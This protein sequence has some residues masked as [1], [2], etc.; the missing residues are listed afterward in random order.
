MLSTTSGSTG[1]AERS[2]AVALRSAMGALHPAPAARSTKNERLHHPRRPLFHMNGTVSRRRPSSLPTPRSWLLPAFETRSYIEAIAQIQSHAAADGRCR[3]CG[4]RVVKEKRFFSSNTIS[5][6]R[7]G[8]LMLGSAPDDHGTVGQDQARR[9]RT[10][11][12][13]SA[14]GHHRG[15]PRPC[16]VR[17]RREFPDTAIGAR[18]IRSVSTTSSWSMATENEGVAADAQSGADEPL[19]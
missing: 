4:R 12:C 6:P 8:R 14:Y 17:I 19:P 13:R 18:A 1:R 3:R 7:S 11:R 9:C 5:T 15:R 2:T 16:S 10:S